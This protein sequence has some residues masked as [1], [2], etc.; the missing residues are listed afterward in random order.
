M[1]R[2]RV[3]TYRMDL[4][5]GPVSWSVVVLPSS[6]RLALDTFSQATWCSRMIVA[7]VPPLQAK[8]IAAAGPWA[9]DGA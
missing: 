5:S 7:G 1:K 4:P 3:E 6:T 2:L 9:H 8:R